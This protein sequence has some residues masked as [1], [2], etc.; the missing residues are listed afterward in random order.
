MALSL[1]SAAT[2]CICRLVAQRPARVLLVQFVGD[3]FVGEADEFR[4]RRVRPTG[5]AG[6]RWDEASQRREWMAVD[7]AG[8]QAPRPRAW[9][10]RSACGNRRRVKRVPG[11]LCV[12]TLR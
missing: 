6:Q 7:Q 12:G 3:A 8:Q 1:C 5:T 2:N 11:R 10:R 4:E 9:G